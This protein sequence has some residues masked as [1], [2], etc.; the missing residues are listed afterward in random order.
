[1]PRTRDEA[2][3]GE[4]QRLYR[5]GLSTRA[6]AAQLGVDPRTVARW[7]GDETRRRGPASRPDVRDA[8]I[9]ALRGEGMSYAEIGRR[10]HMSA[11]GVRMRHYQ[12]TGRVRAR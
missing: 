11:T 5:L 9:L 4:A 12:L 2:Q 3:V 7:L 8:K 1:M 10:V 6:V